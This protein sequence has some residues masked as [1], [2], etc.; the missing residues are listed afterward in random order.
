MTSFPIPACENHCKLTVEILYFYR[1]VHAH[2]ARLFGLYELIQREIPDMFSPW[3][4][5]GHLIK[6][7][8]FL[9]DL[10][11]IQ[12]LPKLREHGYSSE[13]TLCCRLGR[14][15]GKNKSQLSAEELSS[16]ESAISD[17]NEV[18]RRQK[19]NLLKGM[20]LFSSEEKRQDFS[21]FISWL[22]RVIDVTDTELSRAEEMGIKPTLFGAT[23]F[24]HQRG[25]KEAAEL[26]FQLE[27]RLQ[28]SFRISSKFTIH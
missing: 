10:P 21:K 15:Y 18:E 11:K 28:E 12:G 9:H 24:L 27:S 19:D 17:L 20:L 3:K 6:S 7:Y 22:E 14:F 8:L 16:L 1:A 23:Q 13:H 5:E 4:N 25:E 2:R 26:S